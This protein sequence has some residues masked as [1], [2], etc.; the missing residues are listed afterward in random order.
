MLILYYLLQL[1][2]EELLK[3]RLLDSDDRTYLSSNR[4]SDNIMLPYSEQTLFQK[5]V[6]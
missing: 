2:M 5:A 3:S 6:A 4:N 1:H